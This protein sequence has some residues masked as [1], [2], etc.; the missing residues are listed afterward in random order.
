MK[1]RL[2]IEMDKPAIETPP[3]L[4]IEEKVEAALDLIDSGHESRRE[5]C[6]IKCLNNYLMRQ[7]KLSPRQEKILMQIQ[8]IMEKY[9]QMSPTKTE[10]K[11]EYTT[12][13]NK[14]N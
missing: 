1:L 2:K 6:Y 14:D 12:V 5:W 10:Q 11:A 8:P 4:S 13:T 9:G 3:P 7:E